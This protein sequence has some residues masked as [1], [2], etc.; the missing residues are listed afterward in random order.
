MRP[1]AVRF[2]HTHGSASRRRASFAASK[3]TKKVAPAMTPAEKRA[4]EAPD[5]SADVKAA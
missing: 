1:T 4:H 2:S 3:P 5:T